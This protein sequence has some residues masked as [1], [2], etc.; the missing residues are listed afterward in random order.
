MLRLNLERIARLRGVKNISVEMQRNGI[1]KQAAARYNRGEMVHFKLGH[2]EKLCLMLNCTPDD[3][4]EWI[5]DKLLENN[6]TV[7]LNKLKR[8]ESFDIVE[9][10]KNIPLER[11][12]EIKKLCEEIKTQEGIVP[13]K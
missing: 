5:P 9:I 13:G 1:N 12:S 10:S 7:A 8:K 4:I 2:I 11:L 3:I 6:P